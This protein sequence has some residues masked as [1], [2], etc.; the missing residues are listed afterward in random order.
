[1]GKT[2]P[3]PPGSGKK[4]VTTA[5]K[6]PDRTENFLTDIDEALSNFDDQISSVDIDTQETAYATFA[7]AYQ[8]AFA[9]I[10]P[11]IADAS[12]MIWIKFQGTKIF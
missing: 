8:G 4:P 5:A 11:K 3:T 1:M 7:E 6:R 9:N 10:W 12:V 2:K